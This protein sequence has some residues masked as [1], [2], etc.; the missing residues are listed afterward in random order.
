M[1]NSGPERLG[2]LAD[3]GNQKAESLPGLDL[4]DGQHEVLAFAGVEHRE[5][6]S[7]RAHH[8]FHSVRADTPARPCARNFGDDARRATGGWPVCM[9]ASRRSYARSNGACQPERI[10]P[11]VVRA[12]SHVPA[13]SRAG[14]LCT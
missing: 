14:P 12:L 4:A 2:D 6:D 11:Q 9:S 1:R 5:I 8:G 3:R 13:S 10:R 7:R